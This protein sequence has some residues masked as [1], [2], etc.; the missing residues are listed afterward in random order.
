MFWNL[1]TKF[2]DQ[3][4]GNKEVGPSIQIILELAQ[5]HVHYVVHDFIIAAFQ[6]EKIELYSTRQKVCT[7]DNSQT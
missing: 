1:M 4:Y 7:H 2:V 6:P 5:K 3:N